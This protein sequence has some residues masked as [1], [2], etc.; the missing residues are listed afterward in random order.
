[1]VEINLVTAI[2]I[3]AIIGGLV[4]WGITTLIWKYL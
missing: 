3:P 4:G 2:V 1:M